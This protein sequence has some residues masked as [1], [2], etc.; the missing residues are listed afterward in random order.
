MGVGSLALSLVLLVFAVVMNFFCQI[1]NYREAG[2]D[3]LSNPEFFTA[4]SS[5]SVVVCPKIE[6]RQQQQ[7]VKTHLTVVLQKHCNM[8]LYNS[9]CKC[10]QIYVI[11]LLIYLFN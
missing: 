4:A 6:K 7:A 5:L 11:Y 1:L 8:Y 2:D 10:G 9:D 3:L